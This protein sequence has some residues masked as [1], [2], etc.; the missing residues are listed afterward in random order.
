MEK[1]RIDKHSRWAD[2]QGFTDHPLET[3]VEFGKELIEIITDAVAEELI[4][5]H[6]LK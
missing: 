4:E 2:N 5:F 1:P 6:E 3:K